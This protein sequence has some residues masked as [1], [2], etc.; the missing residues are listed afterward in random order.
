MVTECHKTGGK[1]FRK[2]IY[3]RIFCHASPTRG[4]MR[5]AYVRIN[6]RAQS[7]KCALSRVGINKFGSV[8]LNRKEDFV[9]SRPVLKQEFDVLLID[10]QHN[11]IKFSIGGENEFTVG[12]SCWFSLP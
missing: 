6:D 4:L 2:L 7:M 3:F 11:L 5:Y 9:F 1:I 10:S 8:R 12:G